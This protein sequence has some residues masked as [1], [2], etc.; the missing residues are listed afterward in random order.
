MKYIIVSLLLVISFTSLAQ[1]DDKVLYAK[2]RPLVDGFKG[3]VGIYV[4]HLRSGKTAAINADTIFPTA[5]MIK[6]QLVRVVLK[7][8]SIL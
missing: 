7:S 1:K 8:W 5:S 2:L 4:R 3:D 6:I